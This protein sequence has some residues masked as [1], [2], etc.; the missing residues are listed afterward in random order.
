MRATMNISLPE[1]LKDW[2]EKQVSKRGY[3]TASEFVRDVL[4]REKEKE[5]QAKINARLD[6]AIESGASTPLTTGDWRKIRAEGLRM[7]GGR[8][9]NEP[10]D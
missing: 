5:A 2:V 8:R 7:T 10:R 1:S 3:G 6:E 9:K 4:R